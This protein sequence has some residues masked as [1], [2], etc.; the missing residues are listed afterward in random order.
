MKSDNRSINAVAMFVGKTVLTA[1]IYCAASLFGAFFVLGSNNIPLIWPQAGA[2]LALV[3]VFGNTLLP[4][5]FLGALLTGF[6]TGMD[7]ALAG[8]TAFGTVLAT[9]LSAF[10]IQ[11]QKY[12]SKQ[13]DNF[14]SIFI[15]VVAGV[16]LGPFI[17]SLS[18]V[19][20][21]YILQL[22]PIHV[23]PL[24]LQDR[25]LRGALGALSFAPAI[26]IWLGNPLP[27]VSQKKIIEGES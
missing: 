21:M 17:T 27:M 19:I 12:F 3:L 15:L 25:W 1:L 13:L 2:A 23:L 11:Q 18:S 6:F 4:G 7:P 20:G 8:I 10:F 14:Q 5:V 9:Y 26:I 24:V 16:I 22:R